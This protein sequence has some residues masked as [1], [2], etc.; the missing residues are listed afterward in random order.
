MEF[1]LN[2]GT[3]DKFDR[4]VAGWPTN[5]DLVL[6]G[7]YDKAAEGHAFGTVANQLTLALQGLWDRP[8]VVTKSEDLT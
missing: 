7:I 8:W 4:D 6:Q 3:L 1:R 2:L 5:I